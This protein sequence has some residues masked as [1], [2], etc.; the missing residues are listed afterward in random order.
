MSIPQNLKEQSHYWFHRTLK[1]TAL[2]IPQNL[3]EQ[4]HYW[5]RRTLKNKATTD[6]AEP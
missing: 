3:K 1:N 5:F 2:L 6:S 4:G